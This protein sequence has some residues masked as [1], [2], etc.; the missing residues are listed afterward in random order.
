MTG[1]RFLSVAETADALGVSDDLVYELTARREIPSI[2]LG[3]RV[4]VPAAA[5]DE[6]VERTMAGF[7]PDR[8]L[9]TLAAAAPSSDARSAD[10]VAEEGTGTTGLA[11]PIPLR[12]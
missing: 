9:S 10:G 4:M 8:L 5:V 11:T 1:R 6:L 12:R 2:R 3:R 7:D